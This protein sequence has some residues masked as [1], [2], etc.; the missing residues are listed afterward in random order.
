[1]AEKQSEITKKQEILALS[2]MPKNFRVWDVLHNRWFVGNTDEAA[3]ALQTDC[4]HYF[5]EY[6]VMEGTLFDQWE[7]DV[8]KKSAEKGEVS[9]SLDRIQ[10][11]VVVQDTG[12][13]D[14]TGRAIFEGDI[15][16]L[17]ATRTFVTYD[18]QQGR[19]YLYGEVA[20]V[21]CDF[22]SCKNVGNIFE[23]PELC[24]SLADLEK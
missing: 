6:L 11:L 4:V 22:S 14:C 10:Y 8:W 15:L 2:T 23:D 5:G 20:K 3:L 1:M 16:E 24:T 13:K 17:G 12:M 18:S 19:Y 9:C 21:Y 7:D